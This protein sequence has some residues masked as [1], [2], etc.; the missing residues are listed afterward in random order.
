QI[1]LYDK[2]DDAIV[3][4]IV[5]KKRTE[6]RTGMADLKKQV[7][8]P[9]VE[10]LV[11]QY[12]TNGVSIRPEPTTD[13]IGDSKAEGIVFKFTLDNQLGSGQAFWSLMDRRLALLY[14]V[15]PDKTAEKATGGWDLLRKSLTVVAAK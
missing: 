1:S 14:F 9:W 13:T 10:K 3:Q 15:R 2:G 6:S 4:I 7:V 8:D 12:T 11:G 5:L